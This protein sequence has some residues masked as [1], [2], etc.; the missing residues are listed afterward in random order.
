M[1]TLSDQL[2]GALRNMMSA[3]A[4]HDSQA[5][6]LGEGDAALA[7]YYRRRTESPPPEP[8][9]N[10]RI[11]WELEA[12][13]ADQAYFGNALRVALDL[14]G[15]DSDDRAV[16]NRWTTGT[17]NSTDHI[18]L[19]E[20]AAKI[21]SEP[22]ARPRIGIKLEG[23]VVQNV[24]ADTEASVYVINYDVE[25]GAPPS[26]YEDE[27]HG[28]CQLEQDGGATAE[29]VLSR[30]G[31]EVAPTWFPRMDAALAARAPALEVE[32][33]MDDAEAPRP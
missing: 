4:N 10:V 5:V 31:A 20:I 14:P 27:D 7:A 24:F 18:R 29:C 8:Y 15:I 30:Y 1:N 32:M 25:D 22:A 13:A 17:Q 19:Q 33:E 28:V 16:L 9:T 23:G 3:L 21:S 6:Q 26:G 2:A 11:R 12:T